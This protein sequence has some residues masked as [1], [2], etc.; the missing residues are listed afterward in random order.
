LWAVLQQVE[1]HAVPT[2][3]VNLLC[4]IWFVNLLCDIRFVNLLCDIRFVLTATTT[5]PPPMANS[6]R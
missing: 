2:R 4:D 5:P 3:F 6:L 1:S